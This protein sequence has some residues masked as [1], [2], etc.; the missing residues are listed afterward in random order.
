MRPEWALW[1]SSGGDDAAHL[2]V[3]NCQRF[4]LHPS[5]AQQ[6]SEHAAGCLARHKRLSSHAASRL[7]ECSICMELVCALS[8]SP[9]L[10]ACPF[11]AACKALHGFMATLV[12]EMHDLPF[13]MFYD[14]S[15]TDVHRRGDLDEL[16]KQQDPLCRYSQSRTPLSASLACWTAATRSA[17]AASATGARAQRA[18]L[19]SKRCSLWPSSEIC[20]SCGHFIMPPSLRVY[21]SHVMSCQPLPSFL[22]FSACSGMSSRD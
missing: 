3:Q 18:A 13:M 20:T 16:L 19:T 1:S 7:I 21:E 22:P 5:D 11:T 4:A 17:W 15:V 12:G 8:C 10:Y 2:H 9:V 14:E 6:R